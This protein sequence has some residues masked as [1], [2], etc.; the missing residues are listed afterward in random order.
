MGAWLF[1]SQSDIFRCL[2]ETILW[3]YWRLLLIFLEKIISLFLLKWLS[4]KMI[5]IFALLNLQI[6]AFASDAVE[7]SWSMSWVV[8]GLFDADWIIDPRWC[9]CL[10]LIVLVE[11]IFRNRWLFFFCESSLSHFIWVLLDNSTPEPCW[12]QLACKIISIRYNLTLLC[13]K[14]LLRNSHMLNIILLPISFQEQIS[15]RLSLLQYF[16]EQ[17]SI[18][19]LCKWQLGIELENNVQNYRGLLILPINVNAYVQWF[20]LN[21]ENV[22]VMNENLFCLW[23]CYC[24]LLVI[25]LQQHWL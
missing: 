7:R 23:S 9:R 15:S 25:W 17:K 19:P 6:H 14:Y 11:W 22:Y 8:C 12:C 4:T 13:Q 20:L 5:V 21:V 16:P 18:M 3:L 10:V 24:E 1:W 2:A